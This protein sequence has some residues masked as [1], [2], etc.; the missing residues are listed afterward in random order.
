MLEKDSLSSLIFSFYL[1]S[2]FEIK[3]FLVTKKLFHV[4]A[5]SLFYNLISMF[6]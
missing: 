2:S 5:R 3:K 4:S 1:R 6:Y